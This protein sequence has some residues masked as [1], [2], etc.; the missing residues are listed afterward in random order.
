[1]EAQVLN[2]EIRYENHSKPTDMPIVCHCESKTGLALIGDK[3]DSSELNKYKNREL[4]TNI[5]RSY[6]LG[7][8]CLPDTE[9]QSMAPIRGL[10]L[11]RDS[12]PR[13]LGLI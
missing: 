12:S 13:K 7:L 5:E 9:L 3:I 8:V 2:I 6:W 4:I 11:S 10:A 1:M